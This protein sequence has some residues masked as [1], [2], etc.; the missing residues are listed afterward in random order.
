M[1]FRIKAVILAAAVLISLAG[2]RSLNALAKSGPGSTVEHLLGERS[3]SHKVQKSDAEWRIVLDPL[4]YRVMRE[5]E[6]EPPFSGG[7]NSQYAKGTYVC[8]GCGTPLFSSAAKYDSGSG[9]PSFA[10]ALDEKNLEFRKDTSFQMERIEVRCAVCGAHL[11]HLFDDGPAPTSEH[12]CINSA[13]LDFAAAP[14]SAQAGKSP[15]K[16]AGP[17]G[18]SVARVETAVFAAGCFGGSRT[19]SADSRGSSRSG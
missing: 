1:S 6:T 18:P 4:R 2:W 9:W 7:L 16:P 3:M 12:Y 14:R 8:A 10:A 19:S 17:G 11:G 13:S 5:G 15:S